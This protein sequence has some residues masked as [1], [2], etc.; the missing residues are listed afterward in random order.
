MSKLTQNNLQI[1]NMEKAQSHTFMVILKKQNRCCYQWWLIQ[2]M[3]CVGKRDVNTSTIASIFCRNKDCSIHQKFLPILCDICSSNIF[4]FL[5]VPFFLLCKAYCSL[6]VIIQ[7]ICYRISRQGYDKT[8]GE[9]LYSKDIRHGSGCEDQRDFMLS[10]FQ[11]RDASDFICSRVVAL[12]QDGAFGCC[13]CRSC[14]EVVQPGGNF[15]GYFS[16]SGVTSTF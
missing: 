14:L 1:L 4:I 13:Y 8:R 3:K 11:R 2:K 5:F 9:M 16:C 12:S 6:Q 7:S 15:S 10:C